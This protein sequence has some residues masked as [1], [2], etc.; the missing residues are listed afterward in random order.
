MTKMLTVS[1][2]KVASSVCVGEDMKEVAEYVQVHTH[3]A[4]Q[5]V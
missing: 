3:I 2:Q 5:S 1:I 4:L